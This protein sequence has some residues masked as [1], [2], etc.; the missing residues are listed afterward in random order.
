MEPLAWHFVKWITQLVSTRGA[1]RE[2]LRP[3]GRDKSARARRK[4]TAEGDGEL[5][6][7]LRV[8]LDRPRRTGVVNLA[9]VVRVIAQVQPVQRTCPVGVPAR[10]SGCQFL[11]PRAAL[12]SGPSQRPRALAP[13]RRPSLKLNA[14]A[15]ATAQGLGRVSWGAGRVLCANTN[16]NADGGPWSSSS[17]ASNNERAIA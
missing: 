10:A 4:H 12:R 1:T 8:R 13:H 7:A 9:D 11:A 14:P 2:T 6:P 5:P 3:A 17:P 16:A 15:A